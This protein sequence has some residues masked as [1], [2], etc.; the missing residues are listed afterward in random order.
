MI[1]TM[2]RPINLRP[3]YLAWGIIMTD[4]HEYCIWMFNF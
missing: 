3:Q 4:W 1:F 2:F